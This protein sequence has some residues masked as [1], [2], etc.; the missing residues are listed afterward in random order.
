MDGQRLPWAA[1]LGK[2]CLGSNQ[3]RWPSLEG[4][5]GQGGGGDRCSKQKGEVCAK[6]P[7]RGRAG[8]RRQAG[9]AARCAVGFA[10]HAHCG[11]VIAASSIR[12]A[13]PGQAISGEEA[14]APR[15][16]LTTPRLTRGRGEANLRHG[17]SGHGS[18]GRC[19]RYMLLGTRKLPGQEGPAP[20]RV[21]PSVLPTRLLFCKALLSA[22]NHLA[23]WAFLTLC[24]EH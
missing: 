16:E 13:P 23:T 14:E 19:Q 21:D 10:L 4:Q 20:C 12:A 15:A 9:Q 6:A 18:A 24:S 7:R 17:S 3:G 8:P 22:R 5:G 2:R 11:Q 1:Q